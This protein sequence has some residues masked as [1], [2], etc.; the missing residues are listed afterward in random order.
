MPQCSDCS[1]WLLLKSD[2][3]FYFPEQ[4]ESATTALSCS[5]MIVGTQPIR[6]APGLDCSFKSL[7]KF[8][9]TL[10]FI[11]LIMQGKSI[12]D[13]REAAS[14]SPNIALT[15][16]HCPRHMD[17]IGS[18]SQLRETCVAGVVKLSVFF[19]SSVFP[20]FLS[21]QLLFL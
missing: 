2:M 21:Q 20:S 16:H 17:G 8:D 14:Y 12:K 15:N 10:S 3:L 18:T 6:F 4:A 7:T 11:L 19:W 13:T 9:V 5:G 1:K